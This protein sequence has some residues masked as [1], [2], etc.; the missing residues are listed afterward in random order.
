M[1]LKYYREL[2]VEDKLRTL[3]KDALHELKQDID[4]HLAYIYSDRLVATHDEFK[5]LRL[6]VQ[7]LSRAVEQ[8]LVSRQAQQLLRAILFDLDIEE[9]VLTQ[10]MMDVKR[11][12]IHA[13]CG[14]VEEAEEIFLDNK[15][16]A[17]T[18]EQFAAISEVVS[19]LGMAGSSNSVTL[20]AKLQSVIDSFRK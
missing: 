9:A 20:S 13:A 7:T 12:R 11:A 17:S 3:R 10:D 15:P 4:A 16:Y 14:N 19:Y 18:K 8:E 2:L 5:N 6:V 1:N